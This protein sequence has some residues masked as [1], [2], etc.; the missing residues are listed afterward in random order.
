MASENLPAGPPRARFLGAELDGFAY[1]SVGKNRAILVVAADDPSLRATAR[2]AVLGHADRGHRVPCALHARPD[3]CKCALMS[4]SRRADQRWRAAACSGL[5]ARR[6]RGGGSSRWNAEPRAASPARDRPGHGIPPRGSAGR[7]RHQPAR[8][9]PTPTPSL[10]LLD[11]RSPDLI[12]R[13]L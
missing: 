11:D 6:G 12:P 2:V 7:L 13:P 3:V 10:P 1:W 8:G 9:T 4:R 5:P